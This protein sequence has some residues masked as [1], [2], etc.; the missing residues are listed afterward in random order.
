[1]LDSLVVLVA[2]DALIESPSSC[3]AVLTAGNDSICHSNFVLVTL[4]FPTEETKGV[5]SGLIE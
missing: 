4:R 5:S 1:M 3:A 2:A